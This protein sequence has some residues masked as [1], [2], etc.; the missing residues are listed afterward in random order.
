MKY[1]TPYERLIKRHKDVAF[2]IFNETELKILVDWC[3]ANNQSFIV[4]K[5][6]LNG[7]YELPAIFRFN[8]SGI[9]GNQGMVEKYKTPE[10]LFEVHSSGYFTTDI[11]CIIDED[12]YPEYFI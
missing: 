11:G 9:I 3:Y 1:K 4:S 12:L 2:K 10:E 6:Y 5:R 7:D 8:K